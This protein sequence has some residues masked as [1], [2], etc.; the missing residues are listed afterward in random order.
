MRKPRFLYERGRLACHHRG[1]SDA[2]GIKVRA[3]DLDGDDLGE[4]HVPLPVLVGDVVAF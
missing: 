3:Y 1:M 4:V 2:T